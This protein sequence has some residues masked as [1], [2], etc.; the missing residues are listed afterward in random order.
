MSPANVKR[1]S[2]FECGDETPGSMKVK[3]L[4]LLIEYQLIKHDR[5]QFNLFITCAFE[6]EK[7]QYTTR[8]T[9]SDFVRLEQL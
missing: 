6:K 8:P 3:K 1:G 5:G 2:S 7:N 9:P 4:H